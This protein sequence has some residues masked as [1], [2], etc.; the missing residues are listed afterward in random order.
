M[1]NAVIVGLPETKKLKV[2]IQQPESRLR[3]KNR[4]PSGLSGRDNI[5]FLLQAFK[6]IPP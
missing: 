3:Q 2:K 5:T 1:A 4:V 6:R